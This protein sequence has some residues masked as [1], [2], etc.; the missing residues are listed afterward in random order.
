MCQRV[1]KLV[2][3]EWGD[4]DRWVMEQNGS[5]NRLFQMGTECEQ[6]GRDREPQGMVRG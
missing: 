4:F 3:E 2:I 1:L 5:A 6:R